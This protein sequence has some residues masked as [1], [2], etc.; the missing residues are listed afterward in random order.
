MKRISIFLLFASFTTCMWAQSLPLLWQ[1][2]Y[3]GPGD[4]SDK[5]NKI[6]AVPGGDYVAVGFTTRNGKYKDF[7]TVK[8]N[9][10]NMDTLWTRTK[11]TGS[12]D[13]EAIS[14]AVDA[15]GN[16]YVTGYRDGG[17]T[18]DDIYT[19]KYDA[20]GT[21]LWDTAYNDADSAFLDDRPVDCGVDPSGN[22]IIA[23][24]TEQG[25]S[26]VNQNDYLI[27]KYDSNG[28]LLWRTRYNRSGYK[29]EASAMAIDANGDIFVTGRS[30]IL[31]DDDW[32]TMKLDGATG[33][34]LWT[35]V[36]IYSSGNGDDRAVDIALDNAGNP[37]VVGRA[38]NGSNNDQYHL[39][40]YSSAGALL[41][42]KFKDAIGGNA[43]PTS[44]AVDQVNN[45]MYVTG[46]A[47]QSPGST[48]YDVYTVKWNAAGTF[49]WDRTWAGPALNE[50]IGADIVVDPFSN[51]L[52][53]GK[54]D[55]DPDLNHSS[56]D[57]VTLK[58]DASGIIQYSKVKNGTRNDDD[59]A[60]SIVVDASGNAIVAGYINNTSTQKDASRIKYDAI[61][62]PSY[63]KEYNGEGD[64]NESSKAMVQDGSGN[65][66]I[67]GYAYVETDNKNIFAGKIDP[68]GNLVDTFLMNGTN[69]ADDELSAI[70][71]DG[72]GNI[73][74][75]GYTKSSGEKSNFIL[76]KFNSNLVVQWDTT[77]NYIN[78]SD[79]AV[80]LAADG[81]GIYVTGVSDADPND[82]IAN[83]DIVT[84][85]YDGSGNILWSQRYNN[86]FNF[87]DEPV[88]LILGMNNRVYVT[89]RT[90]NIHDDDIILLSYDQTTGNP[91]SGFPAIWNSNFA[92]DDRA[93]DIVEDA[94]GYV[95]VSGYSQSSSFVEDYTLLKYNS[96]GV[97][98]WSVSYDG[99]AS[100]ED[101]ANAI[102]L[103][104]TGNIIVAGQTDVDNS[105]ATN[106]NYGTLIY[107]GTGNY[108]CSA[109]VPFTYNGSGDGDDV[110][111]AVNV[112]GNLI[113]ITGQS[114][115]GTPQARNK[116]I[117]VRIYDESACAEIP[118]FAEYDGPA[119]GGDAPN[120]T[121]VTASTIFIT[122]SSDGADNQKDII[123]LKYDINTGLAEAAQASISSFVYPNPFN[124]TAVIQL[125]GSATKNR[126]V[127][128]YNVL[129]EV[130]Y[131]LGN[132]GAS[133]QLDK[134]EFPDGVYS[135]KVFEAG[136]TV[137]GGRFVTN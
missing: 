45:D 48:D 52:I 103:D 104:A 74:A 89:G 69:D 38:K 62:N 57:W 127:Q 46:E 134:N 72:N 34:Q 126:S 133:I 15:S 3:A 123:T 43:R 12:G 2:R 65:T 125:D 28:A 31:T 120:A 40:K 32:V 59:E 66:Y 30:A 56:Y 44:I 70:A 135:Y 47:D 121:F 23:G 113:L 16:I 136:G 80:S 7:L 60:A 111:V 20:S 9:G 105:V 22:F 21:D 95:Y 118:E 94:G 112:N 14:C 77:Y 53:C 27:L 55:A 36:K 92:D 26:A 99:T 114:A 137:A 76:I 68:S 1:S 101:R 93:S 73:Y 82:T 108:V 6:I 8:I 129:G 96:S 51:I 107:D 119:G 25:T 11:G 61:G 98:D 5:F 37:C 117:M 10:A 109:A 85:K 130:V 78:Q 81:S 83:D 86:A 90:S 100:N 33:N 131:Q 19:I 75:C 106:Y 110:S 39:L 97:L 63:T 50:D 24:W 13:D 58:Y 42:N 29:D 116:N 132:I 128:V 41:V 54:T 115:E 64:F 18:S 49:Q 122:G 79:K 87:R 84:I 4:N 102:A 91:V 124:S 88:K 17:N 71:T 67:A 35:P